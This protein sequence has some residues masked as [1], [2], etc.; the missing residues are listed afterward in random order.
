MKRLI[1]MM[2]MVLAVAGSI[3]ASI[4]DKDA[5]NGQEKVDAVRRYQILVTNENSVKN[6][7]NFNEQVRSLQNISAA[8]AKRDWG[9]TS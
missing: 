3:A 8:E 7:N 5:Q 6:I 1:T 4:P 9:W 2:L